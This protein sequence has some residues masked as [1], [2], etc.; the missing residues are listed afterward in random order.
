[1]YNKKR[2]A[3]YLESNDKTIFMS[4]YFICY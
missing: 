2:I 1:M 4:L 3:A